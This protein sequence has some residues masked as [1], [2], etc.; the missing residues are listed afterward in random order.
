V[1]VAVFGVGSPTT[2]GTV[3]ILLQAAVVAGF[4]A[5]QTVGLRRTA[6]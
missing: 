5:L 1:V 6:R 2:A 3:W 4:A